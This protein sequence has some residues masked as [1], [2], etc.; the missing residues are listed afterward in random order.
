MKKIQVMGI[1]NC[2]PDSFYDGGRYKAIEQALLLVE[3]GADIIDIGGESTRPGHTPITEEEELQRVLPVVE[4]LVNTT[5]IP[6]SIDTSK[7]KV[8]LAAI[9]RGASWINDVTGFTN[10]LMRQV[11]KNSHAPIVVMHSETN[12]SYPKGVIHELL[13]WF[14]KQIALLVDEGIALRH[15]M[16]DPGIGFGKSVQEN[17]DILKN[18]SQLQRFDVPILIGL[19]R[20][21]FISKI[22]DK[23][24]IELLSTTI[25][26]N[27]MSMLYGANIIRVHDVKEHR[28]VI[29]VLQNLK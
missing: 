28:E 4:A 25:A 22:L 13:E 9:E 27:T 15:I 14:T 12:P 5:K 20:K 21:S 29:N 2:T 6:I 24:A 18:L 1:V 7:P 17:I 19:S 16:I 8:A 11:A 10:P 3:Q 23:P 26:L